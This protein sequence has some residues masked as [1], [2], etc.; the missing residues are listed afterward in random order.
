VI[1]KGED[2]GVPSS[3]PPDAVIE[4]DDNALARWVGTSPGGRARFVP[5]ADSDLAR[6]LGMPEGAR[7]TAGARDEV[8]REVT[9]DALRFADGHTGTAVNMV[10]LGPA[11]DRLRFGARPTRLRIVLDGTP[12][13]EGPATTL[14]VANGEFLR[15]LDVV[16]RGHP[17][18]GRV[19]V[20]VYR[21]RRGERRPMRV[22]LATGTHLPHPRIEQRTARSLTVAAADPLPLEVDGRLLGMTVE[23][24]VEVVPDAYRLLL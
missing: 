23:V 7:G 13:F 16:P 11:P 5:S 17:G 14:V 3:A 2:W 8:A 18:D 12:M 22:R 10:I 4:G 24:A 6:V 21:L 20:Q 19:E 15:G 9:L 1:R